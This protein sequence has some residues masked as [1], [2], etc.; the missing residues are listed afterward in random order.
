MEE[1]WKQEPIGR[2]TN[3]LKVNSIA[4]EDELKKIDEEEEQRMQDAIQFAKDSPEP[5]PATAEEYI[6]A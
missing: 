4:E 3:Y 2:F 5:D 1:F 6:Y